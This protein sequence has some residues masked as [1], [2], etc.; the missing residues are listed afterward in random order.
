M[1]SI[2]V[3]SHAREEMIDITAEVEA[4][5]FGLRS[6]DLPPRQRDAATPPIQEE[7]LREESTTS[8]PETG[9]TPPIQ[10]ESFWKES[11]EQTA[12]AL[13]T[14]EVKRNL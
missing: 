2:L 1:D 5:I 13:A 10:E 8:S 11:A 9:A 3:Q 7:S 4:V 6:V 12:I 14:G